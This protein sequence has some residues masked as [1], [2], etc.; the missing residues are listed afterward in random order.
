MPLRG[1]QQWQQLKEEKGVKS[2]VTEFF[3][4]TGVGALPQA[5][6]TSV[7][8]L[9]ALWSIVFIVGVCGTITHSIFIVN[10]Y[11]SYPTQVKVID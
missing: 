1:E 4:T 11:Y 7:F 9:K 5:Y 8:A 10:R 2:S 3:Q 6:L